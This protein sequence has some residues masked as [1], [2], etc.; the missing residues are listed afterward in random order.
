MP[1]FDRRKFFA[2]GGAGVLAAGGTGAKGAEAN[3]LLP[4]LTIQ[5]RMG[6]SEWEVLVPDWERLPEGA[7]LYQGFL[8]T[9]KWMPLSDFL[10][11]L[12][13]EDF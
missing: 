13:A 5:I 3:P 10:T 2:L 4:G 6:T 9:T 11:E 12:I 8:V 1:A 7:S